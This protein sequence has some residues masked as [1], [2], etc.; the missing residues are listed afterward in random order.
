MAPLLIRDLNPREK[1]RE[2]MVRVGPE[3][4]TEEELIAILLRSGDRN[5]SAVDLARELIRNFEGL[6]GLL[7]A[8]TN[9]LRKIKGVGMAKAT[10]IKAAFELGLRI[11]SGAHNLSVITKPQDVYNL[12]KKALFGKKREYLYVISLDAKNRVLGKDLISAGTPNETYVHPKEIYRSALAKSASSV[13]LVHNHP[14]G[15]T[16]PSSL[17]VKVTNQVAEM[18]RKIDIPLLDHLIMSDEGF[19]SLKSLSLFNERLNTQE[20]GVNYNNQKEK[21][22]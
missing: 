10:S 18:G 20:G 22:K 9:N 2:K 19:T 8:D 16:T 4:L 5:K 17:D 12:V 3:N 14:S 7:S 13:V 21:E 6:K 15:D 11:N 1:P